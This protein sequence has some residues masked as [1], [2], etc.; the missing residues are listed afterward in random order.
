MITFPPRH[1]TAHFDRRAESSSSFIVKSLVDGTGFTL[2]LKLGILTTHTDRSNDYRGDFEL[3]LETTLNLESWLTSSG[4]SI[5]FVA[6]TEV[7]ESL[8][9]RTTFALLG[10]TR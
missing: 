1:R 5:V 4:G 2:V 9:M 7:T 6:C 8:T 10:L 3:A